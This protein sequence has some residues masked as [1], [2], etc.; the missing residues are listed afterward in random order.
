MTGEMGRKAQ[1]GTRG[2]TSF[3]APLPPPIKVLAANMVVFFFFPVLFWTSED[4][5]GSSS[6]LGRDQL[7]G[8][9]L[10]PAVVFVCVCVYVC[11]I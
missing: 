5:R 2:S 7:T 3:S 1:K 4:T 6:W 8:P 11:L 10:E 9:E